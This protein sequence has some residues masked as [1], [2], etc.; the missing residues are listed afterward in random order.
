MK[1]L[2][3]SPESICFPLLGLSQWG[4]NKVNLQVLTSVHG[5]D[6]MGEVFI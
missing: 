2:A 4:V 5:M 1:C 3:M 6:N